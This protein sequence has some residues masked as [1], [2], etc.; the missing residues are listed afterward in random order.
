MYN[1]TAGTTAFAGNQLGIFED[2]DDIYSQTDLNDF[3]KTFAT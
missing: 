1:I 2:L 3:F